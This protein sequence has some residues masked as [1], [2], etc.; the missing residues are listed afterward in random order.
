[1]GY[2]NSRSLCGVGQLSKLLLKHNG[3]MGSCDLDVITIAVSRGGG[4]LLSPC[5]QRNTGS[6]SQHPRPSSSLITALLS[7][8]TSVQ[9][10]GIPPDT[11]KRDQWSSSVLADFI[12]AS[13]EALDPA[14]SDSLTSV[15]QILWDVVFLKG[16]ISL[17]GKS[18]HPSDLQLEALTTRLR[19]KV[20]LRW[21]TPLRTNTDIQLL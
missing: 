18:M 3:H 19:D 10:I 13:S 11:S 8:S 6:A 9:Q 7:L 16:M 12:T 17:W 14:G 15:Q 2:L 5:A 4:D 1:M 20:C 21:Y